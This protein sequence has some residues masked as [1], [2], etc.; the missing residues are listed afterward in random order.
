MSS[1]SESDTDSVRN[2]SPPPTSGIVTATSPF[3]ASDADLI[4]CS[5]NRVDFRVHRAIMAV[6]SRVFNDMLTLP[7]PAN[8][9]DDHLAVV[10][11]TEDGSTLDT[12]LRI[13]YPVLDPTIDSIDLARPVLDAA[14]KYDIK[15][16][17]VYCKRA[18]RRLAKVQPLRVYA[19]ACLLGAEHTARLA[20]QQAISRWDQFKDQYVPEFEELSAG[21][22]HRLLSYQRHGSDVGHPFSFSKGESSTY[23]AVSPSSPEQLHPVRHAPFP[24]DDLDAE[25]IMVSSDKVHFRV[26]KSILTLASQ[27]FKAMLQ[28][29]TPCESGSDGSKKYILDIDEDSNILNTLLQFCYPIG[30]PPAISPDALPTLRAALKYKLDRAIW[31]LRSQWQTLSAFDPLCAYLLAASAG[32]TEEASATAK[33][34]LLVNITV[35]QGST[36]AELETT[37]A[38]IY[39]RLLQ[40]HKKCAQMTSQRVEMACNY[41]GLWSKGRNIHVEWCISCKV[42]SGRSDSLWLRKYAHEA[43]MELRRR[44]SPA[45]FRDSY[46]ITA[47]TRSIGVQSWCDMHAQDLTHVHAGFANEIESVLAEVSKWKPLQGRAK[48]D[49]FSR[50]E[51]RCFSK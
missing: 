50:S 14:L 12:L 39:Y 2:H 30:T 44:P 25:V 17:I 34:L 15:V 1:D 20:A 40:Y 3:D 21:C 6:A 51:P 37:S 23:H 22:Y 43:S 33:S 31:Y 29:T 8:A 13:C 32:W 45:I 7:Q 5:S 24:F 18:L 19:I 42:S 9:V 11:L 26:F 49:V 27:V 38:G 35:L 16:A 4:L 36:V 48:G 41:T 10:D 47:M 46:F 28:A